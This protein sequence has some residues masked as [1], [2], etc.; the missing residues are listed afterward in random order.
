[1]KEEGLRSGRHE[2]SFNQELG[3]FGREIVSEG[4]RLLSLG[5]IVRGGVFPRM[6]ENGPT[7][8]I[9]MDHRRYDEKGLREERT[10]AFKWGIVSK[11]GN[12]LQS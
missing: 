11:H 8:H 2:R 10:A 3:D 5:R 9:R 4:T 12:K 1:M 7:L 6:C